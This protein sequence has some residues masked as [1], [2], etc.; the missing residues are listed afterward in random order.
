MKKKILLTGVS[1]FLGSHLAKELLAAG[2]EVIALKRKSSS[3]H[4]VESIVSKI[5]LI[6]IEALNFDKLFQ[7]FGKIDAIIH[8]A[9][10]Y[11]R[12]NES[13]A[14]IFNANTEFPLRL[15][16][17]GSR[18]GVEL[19]INTDTVLDKYLN[20][21]ALTKKQ[22]LQWGK[23]FTKNKRICFVNVRLEHFYGPDDETS[24]F[25]TYIVN[26]CIRNVPELKLTK[27]EQIRDFIYIDD[28]VSAYMAL[29]ENLGEVDDFFIEIELGSGKSVSIRQFVEMAH[30][31]SESKTKLDF[32]A[33]PYREGEIMCSQANIARLISLGWHC[34]YD[35]EAGLNKM[36]G[37]ERANI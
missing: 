17:S 36:I 7:D 16:E 15:L 30:Q 26:S 3:L 23:F 6:D 21:Y 22:F 5:K 29:L 2:Y 25:P 10:C 24:K 13:V 34:R 8:T 31:I 1:G 33:I 28:V 14:E 20:I 32:G 37:I 19:F 35:L 9:T 11:G 27:G 18:L 12:N 4:R